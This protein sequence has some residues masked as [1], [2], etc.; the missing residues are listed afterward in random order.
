[1]PQFLLGDDAA[2]KVTFGATSNTGVIT[3]STS[4]VYTCLAQKVS[5]TDSVETINVKPLCGSRKIFRPHSGSTKL[6]VTLFTPTTGFSTPTSGRATPIGFPVKIEILE[7]SALSTPLTFIG[8]VTDW[9]TEIAQGSPT[10]E[11]ISVLCDI[12]SN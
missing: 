7:S 3:F 2:V 1:M 8:I 6:D 4:V 12:S 5:V 9:K 11:T 10:M